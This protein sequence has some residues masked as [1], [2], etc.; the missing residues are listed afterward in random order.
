VKLA[1][2]LL[3]AAAGLALA[4]A[5]PATVLPTAAAA[6]PARDGK[7]DPCLV[8]TGLAD[9]LACWS[10]EAAHGK[11]VLVTLTQSRT[12][13][14][15][16]KLPAAGEVS[17][18]ADHLTVVVPDQVETGS[19]GTV[20]LAL[21]AHRLVAPGATVTAPDAD[22]QKRLDR[23]KGCEDDGKDF[24][25][26]V[27]KDKD[28]SG[29]DLIGKDLAQDPASAVWE[30][31]GGSGGN[32]WVLPTALGLALAALVAALVMLVRGAGRSPRHAGAGYPAPDVPPA[33]PPGRPPT[34]GR[35]ATGDRN[36]DL[37]SDTARS[38][39][40]RTEGPRTETATRFLGRA[41][42]AGRPAVVRTVLHPQ[43]YVELDG[44][45]YRARWAAD[46]ESPGVGSPVQ[47]V[48]SEAGLLAYPQN[49]S[50]RTADR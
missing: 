39:G 34:G 12:F 5:A 10:R 16:A 38:A 49:R 21:A 4:V 15:D 3:C 11:E 41:G 36:E 47:V 27:K 50:G 42:A 37:R 8:E 19:G 20:L 29:A 13:A 6:V 7:T 24:C 9:Q 18:L 26:A 14:K 22:D 30:S 2:L 45:L 28:V 43:G 32:G 33:A 23:M 40:L 17:R 1:A 46:G 48:D 35:R 31:G 44:L 25:R